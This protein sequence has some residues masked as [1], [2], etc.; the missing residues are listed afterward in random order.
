MITRI[1]AGAFEL[2]SSLNFLPNRALQ[3]N[4]LSVGSKHDDPN[5]HLAF[6]PP[7]KGSTATGST[8]IQR[9]DRSGQEE[10]FDFHVP[11]YN[12]YWMGG[13]FHHNCGK[14]TAARI[15][16]KKVGCHKNDLYELNCS[17]FNGIETIR[18]IRKKMPLASMNGKCKVWL[19]DECHE[20]SSES[21]NGFL[22]MLED[23]PK[24][25]YFFLCTSLPEKLKETIK[26]RCTHLR[27]ERLKDTE[28]KGCLLGV[29]EWL[30]GSDLAGEKV[31]DRIVEISQGSARSALVELNKIIGLKNDKER[32]AALVDPESEVKGIEIARELMSFKPSW[33]KLTKILKEVKEDPEVI[34]NIVLSYAS[35]VMLSNRKLAPRCYLI[36]CAFEENFFY[37]RKAGLIRA[38]YDVCGA[39]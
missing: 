31:V 27:F 9:I 2:S 14:T 38:C 21:Q 33:E 7:V 39:K 8:I 11:I 30:G 16:A 37:S 29:L 24:H 6:S 10:Y 28:I 3:P 19:L 4:R 36:L 26:N 5:F 20:W 25:V 12:N 18:S 23:T 34:R 22:K 35:T 13:L 1:V 32:L 17:D 15:L